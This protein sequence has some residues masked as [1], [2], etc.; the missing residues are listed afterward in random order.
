MLKRKHHYQKQED[1]KMWNFTAKSK[2]IVK[3]G[4]HT[5]INIIWKPVPLRVGEYSSLHLGQPLLGSLLRSP[6]FVC[7]LQQSVS[8][9]L[10]QLWWRYVGVNGDLLQEGLGEYRCR[11]FE[12]NCKLTNQQTKTILYIHKLLSTNFMGTTKWK[13]TIDTHKEEKGIQTQH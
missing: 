3:V 10:C 11:L 13:S 5:H 8:P 9:V 2:Y 12:V 7:A 4:S 1:S 6:G